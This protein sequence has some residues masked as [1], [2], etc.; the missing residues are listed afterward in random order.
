MDHVGSDN[1][2]HHTSGPV[3]Q[4]PVLFPGLPYSTEDRDCTSLHRNTGHTQSSSRSNVHD[5]TCT[6]PLRTLTA[7]YTDNTM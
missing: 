2:D 4:S 3:S 6:S 7:V 5:L 1:Q